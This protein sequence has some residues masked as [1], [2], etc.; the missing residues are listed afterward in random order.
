MLFKSNLSNQQINKHLNIT[1]EDPA[2][3]E[4]NSKTLELSYI[5]RIV[6]IWVRYDKA[7]N[8]FLMQMLLFTFMKSTNRLRWNTSILNQSPPQS[9]YEKSVCVE[10]VLWNW[11][12]NLTS[13]HGCKSCNQFVL[14]TA[15]RW[16][17]IRNYISTTLYKTCLTLTK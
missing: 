8:K 1:G 3:T 9:S 14:N 13:K 12:F 5:G 11:P 2:F 10:Q 16:K 17:C 6:S 7:M 4:T 15:S